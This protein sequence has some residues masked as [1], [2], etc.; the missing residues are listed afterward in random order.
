MTPA[1]TECRSFDGLSKRPHN[2]AR[3]VWGK[4]GVRVRFRW[5]CALF[6]CVSVGGVASAQYESPADVLTFR[7]E[8]ADVVGGETNALC[9]TRRVKLKLDQN[10]MTAQQAVV[11]VSGC[12]RGRRRTCSG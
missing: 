2:A 12:C 10:E 1:P 6:A 3:R 5:I 9:S 4:E 8:R 7:R 11:W